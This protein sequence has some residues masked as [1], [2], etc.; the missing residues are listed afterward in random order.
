MNLA[1]NALKFTKEGYVL[2][3]I[4]AIA[5]TENETSIQFS[6]KDTGIGVSRDELP[7][8]FKKF[9]QGDSSTTREF[10]G[11]GLGL[12]ICKQLVNLMGGKIGME[13]ELGKGSEF[14]FRL[15]LPIPKT[16]CQS[17]IDTTLFKREPVLIIDEKKIMGHALA[18]WLNRWGLTSEISGTLTEAE[19]KLRE[20]SYRIIFIGEHLACNTD[21]PFF[22]R[23]EFEQIPLFVI[24][25]ITNRGFR[26][27]DRAGLTANLIKPIRHSTLL[28]KTAGALGYELDMQVAPSFSQ[29]TSKP[30]VEHSSILKVESRRILVTED[31]LVNQTVAKRMLSKGGFEVDVAE[32]GEVALRKMMSDVQYDLIFMD[33]Q[34]P[35]MDGYEA[36][37]QIRTFEKEQSAESRIPII[38]LTANAMQGD[39][40]KCLE[41]GMDDYVPKPVKKEAL[42]DMINRYLT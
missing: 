1:S 32:N 26:T 14:W 19:Q 20:T 28:S 12:A 25:S 40:E 37:R 30:Q 3:D 13:S 18:E 22:Q 24:C 7:Q 2:I 17:A 11:T 5:G 9:S 15:N 21:A 33:C 10:G 6:I 42:F 35:R 38:A 8:L 29:A 16:S 4:E 39:R 27:M 23:P 36:C 41:A 31:N 34:M